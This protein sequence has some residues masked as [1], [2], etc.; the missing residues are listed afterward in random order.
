MVLDVSYSLHPRAYIDGNCVICVI[1]T[2]S[3]TQ[4]YS[5]LLGQAHT[6]TVLFVICVI[7]TRSITQCYSML[8]E[9]GSVF[10]PTR[11]ISILRICKWAPQKYELR[12]FE[13]LPPAF[14]RLWAGLAVG[15][16]N[17]VQWERG[18]SNCCGAMRPLRRAKL[19]TAISS[20]GR[21]LS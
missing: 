6:N 4:C 21:I 2:R 16:I 18:R 13:V 11:V 5:V 10:L 3:I 15:S 17:V 14:L 20:N 1:E 8:L 9:A 7:E 19:G 12:A